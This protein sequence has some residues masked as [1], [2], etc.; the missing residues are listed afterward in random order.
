[1]TNPQDKSLA[2][3][4]LT[5]VDLVVAQSTKNQLKIFI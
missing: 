5:S 1:M 3:G 2:A 4:F